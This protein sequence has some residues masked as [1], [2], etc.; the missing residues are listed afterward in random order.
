M[1]SQVHVVVVCKSELAFLDLGSSTVVEVA[2]GRALSAGCAPSLSVWMDAEVRSH[3]RTDLKNKLDAY[4][5]GLEQSLFDHVQ[6]LSA[7]VILV[8]DAQRPLTLPVSFDRVAEMVSLETSRVCPAH[9]VVDTLKEVNTDYVI[10]GTV[11]RNQ[12]QALSS[13]E[14]YLKSEL[15]KPTGAVW[16]FDVATGKTGYVKGD[17]E[18]IRI[19]EAA[20]VLLVESFLIWQTSNK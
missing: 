2:I 15:R 9:V 6:S 12:V 3:L 1:G 14:G 7:E 4:N 5:L 17:Q 10:S 19:R 8:H 13:P 20:D 18:S 16:N 11:D